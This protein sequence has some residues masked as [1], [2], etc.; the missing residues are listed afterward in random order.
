MVS[1]LSYLFLFYYGLLDIGNLFYLLMCLF[2]FVFVPLVLLHLSIE[3]PFAVSFALESHSE[4]FVILCSYFNGL[5]L[6]H[7]L[8]FLP[9]PSF[10]LWCVNFL[11]IV[12]CFGG[13]ATF[14]AVR[15]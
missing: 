8:L 4:F 14:G 2:W 10:C 5:L 9:L 6:Y 12:L 13:Q 1:Y 15:S 7:S 11:S 3:M